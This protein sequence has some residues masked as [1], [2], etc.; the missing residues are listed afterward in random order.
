MTTITIAFGDGIGH[1]VMDVTLTVMREAGAKLEIE[2]IQVG[3]RV[4]TMGSETGVL[5]S[6]WESLARTR[7]LLKGPVGRPEEKKNITETICEKFDI[8]I[9]ARITEQ[10][11]EEPEISAVGYVSEQFALF[12]PLQDAM[13]ELAGKNKAHP[14]AMLLAA[15]MMLEHIGQKTVADR[16][17][18]ALQ[19]ALKSKKK[20]VRTQKFAE[21]MIANL[22][23]H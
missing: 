21:A 10:C 5:P 2:T 22:Y 17:R 6:S 15:A 23:T 9:A 3:E 14:G 20:K 12:E 4:Y 13:P 18:E 7:V 16:V 11:D 8:D 1:E 19:N